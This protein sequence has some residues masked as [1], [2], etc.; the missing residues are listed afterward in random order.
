MAPEFV[1]DVADEFFEQYLEGDYAGGAS[2]LVHDDSHLVARPLELGEGG[3]DELRLRDKEGGPHRQVDPVVLNQGAFSDAA[4]DV[5]DVDD[6]D[7]VVVIPLVDRKAGV[8][9]F[10]VK[11]VELADGGTSREPADLRAGDHD[12]VDAAVAEAE[13]AIEEFGVGLRNGAF[14]CADA[15]Q[16]PQFRL[17]DRLRD[18][19]TVAEENS[20]EEIG[21]GG[22]RD[23]QRL[24]E[25][26][27]PLHGA[28]DEQRVAVTRMSGEDLR[29]YLSE[30]RDNQGHQDGAQNQSSGATNDVGCQ[31]PTHG[32]GD[33]HREILQ[34]DDEGKEALLL[35]LQPFHGTCC[36]A[37]PFDEMPHAYAAHGD[38]RD[39]DA[40]DERV[41]GDARN[42]E[43]RREFHADTADLGGLLRHRDRGV[44]S[45]RDVHLSNRPQPR[46]ETNVWIIAQKVPAGLG[47][48]R[49]P[50]VTCSHRLRA[51]R[52]RHGR[53]FA[54]DCTALGGP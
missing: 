28:G 22:S 53:R 26:H 21:G 9:V 4:K 24:K 39:L 41:A 34:D 19:G 27:Q 2:V 5:L 31:D 52:N 40:V 18:A 1:A 33:Y 17:G 15:D 29:R 8:G 44:A 36:A 51:Q 54:D 16:H 45:I 13:D 30:D 23:H 20:G 43:D 38:D 3:A 46:A 35:R 6:P 47:F 10:K 12:L 42:E 25:H 7:D 48:F 32:G 49:T 37:A 11:G 14:F 50:D